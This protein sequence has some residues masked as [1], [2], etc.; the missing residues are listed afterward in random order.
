[1]TD[2]PD[3][4]VGTTVL[5][6][7][8]FGDSATEVVVKFT[9]QYGEAAHRLLSDV[10]L[11]PKLHWCGPIIG[12]LTMVVM[13]HLEGS[14]SIWQMQECLKPKPVADAVL[15][16][17]KGALKLL[18]KNGLVF[19]DFRDTNVVVSKGRGFLVDFDWAGKDG[20]DRYPAAL[21]RSNKWHPE[22]RAHGVMRKAHDDWQLEQL[23]AQLK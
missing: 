20:E 16:D 14:E 22:V 9:G 8:T 12:G 1:M 3:L 6:R 7:A 18:H 2:L 15:K 5:Y 17:A 4:A 11:A 10:N 13:E 23:E 21:N 19:G